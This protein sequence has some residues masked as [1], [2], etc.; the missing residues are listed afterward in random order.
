MGERHTEES[1]SKKSHRVSAS[2]GSRAFGGQQISNFPQQLLRGKWLSDEPIRSGL[3]EPHVCLAEAASHQDAE[4]GMNQA[5]LMNELGDGHRKT[6]V[7]RDQK[8]RLLPVY[9][10][11]GQRFRAI[12]ERLYDVTFGF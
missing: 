10:E 9:L 5:T 4:S 3:G 11:G 6:A 2:G 12:V 8:N 7:V 1:G